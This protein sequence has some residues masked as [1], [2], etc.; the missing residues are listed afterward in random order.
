MSKVYSKEE[1]REACLKYFNGD[2][3]SVST[4]MNK[5]MLKDNDGNYLELDPD[6]MLR[7]RICKEFA[8]GRS[9]SVWPETNKLFFS[10]TDEDFQVTSN[11]S[12][13]DVW[14]D[15]GTAVF[16][17]PTTL[18]GTPSGAI[19]AECDTTHLRYALSAQAIACVTGG[20]E[21]RELNG[22]SAPFSLPA[23]F[24]EWIRTRPAEKARTTAF[25][26]PSDG[27]RP[28]SSWEHR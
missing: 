20:W 21:P 8:P 2:E 23:A 28:I 15:V 1:V 11:A 25:S 6:D 16:L 12:S 3:L 18:L 5:Y 4:A 27:E 26:E 9:R 24:F 17:S 13:A 14:S 7:N 22:R 19:T 10:K